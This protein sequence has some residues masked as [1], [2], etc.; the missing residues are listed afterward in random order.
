MGAGTKYLYEPMRSLAFGS[1]TTSY[2][3]LANSGGA[4]LLHPARQ[5][6]VKNSTDKA[7]IIGWSNSTVASTVTDAFELLSN[8]SIVL[9]ITT[10]KTPVAGN[11]VMGQGEIIYA[12]LTAAGAPASGNVRATVFYAAGD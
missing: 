11:L 3:A 7:I 4:P 5:V 6:L 1:L 2:V 12:K 10:N 8:E 9:D